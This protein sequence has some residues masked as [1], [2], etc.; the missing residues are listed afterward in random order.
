[1]PRRAPSPNSVPPSRHSATIPGSDRWGHAWLHGRLI[2]IGAAVIR[3]PYADLTGNP[4]A[5]K[6]IDWSRS[7]SSLMN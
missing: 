5:M 1:M 4:E 3:L 6:N 2:G 7:L